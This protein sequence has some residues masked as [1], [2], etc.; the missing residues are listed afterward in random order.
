[1]IIDAILLMVATEFIKGCVLTLPCFNISTNYIIGQYGK[2]QFHWNWILETWWN[3]MDQVNP[4]SIKGCF[5]KVKWNHYETMSFI[6]TCDYEY[7]SSFI[8]ATTFLQ[9]QCYI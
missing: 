2:R 9:I 1:M 4:K 5:I 8:Q 6:E 3:I 7:H